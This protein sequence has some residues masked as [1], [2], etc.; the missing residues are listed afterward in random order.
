MNA[1]GRPNTCKS[2]GSTVAIL[3]ATG[4]RV[5]NAYATYPLQA[6]SSGKLGLSRHKI[7]EWHHLVIKLQEVKDGHASD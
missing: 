3:V 1:S 7:I 2:R 6:D 4:A 5:R